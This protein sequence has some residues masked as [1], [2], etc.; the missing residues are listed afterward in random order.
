MAKKPSDKLEALI[1]KE[2]LPG[3][4]V[5][6]FQQI[7][8]IETNAKWRAT[9]AGRKEAKDFDGYDEIE[10]SKVLEKQEAQRQR[11]LLKVG[12]LESLYN[13]ENKK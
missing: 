1:R 6:V 2:Y 5:A 7:L 3:Q 8:D 4:I 13:E 11:L 10:L 9:D 12:F